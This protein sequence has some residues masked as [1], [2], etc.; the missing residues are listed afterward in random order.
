MDKG[1]AKTYTQTIKIIKN[2]WIGNSQN[3]YPNNSLST[4][5]VLSLSGIKLSLS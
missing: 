5:P 4:K 1:T 3:L 2:I